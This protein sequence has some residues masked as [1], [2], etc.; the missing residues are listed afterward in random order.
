M[1]IHVSLITW[2]RLSLTRLCLESLLRLTPSGYEL[3]IVDNGSSDGTRQYL[4]AVA[5]QNTHI[6][7]KALERN[8]GLCV[9]SN[10]AWDDAADADCCVKLDNDLEI[11]SPDWL[12]RLTA[13][14][15]DASDVGMA[16]YR[17]CPWHGRSEKTLPLRGG[18]TADLTTVC[19]GGC[20]AI[21]RAAHERLG[22]WNEGYG[23]YGHE[24]QDYSWR[25]A[26]AGYALATLSPDGYLRH[27]GYNNGAVDAGIEAIKQRSNAAKIS[28]ETAYQL[29]MLLFDEG[30]LPLKTIRKYL[31]IEKDG[32]Y[33]FV[34]N[35][36]YRP[37]QKIMQQLVQT[38]QVDASGR[39]TKVDLSRWK[40]NRK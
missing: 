19:G 28:G 24:D 26:K 30:V 34:M 3:T 25:A 17:L 40:E 12:D 11:L 4:E 29:F 31:P 37:V 18:G 16:A 7:L 20:V 36:K 21:S 23:L 32:R 39:L 9:A 10:L 35:P 27:M 13:V 15:E 22:F 14:F 8:M 33:G 6:H 2:N 1:R 5:G 38:V